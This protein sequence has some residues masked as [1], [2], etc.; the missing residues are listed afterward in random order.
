MAFARLFPELLRGLVLVATKAGP[1]TPEGA[2]GRRATADQVRAMG[3]QVVVD[4]MAPKML[5]AGNPDAP[6]AARVRAIMEPS[7]PEG[8][9]AALLGLADRPDSNPLLAGIRVPTLVVSGTSDALIPHAESEKLAGAIPGAILRL[10]PNAGHLVALEQA[11]EFN[12]AL[13]EWLA[14]L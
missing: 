10:I 12:A 11:D 4:A 13:R 3:S 2:A 1:D 8:V 9:S 5:A 14:R 7:K 6:L